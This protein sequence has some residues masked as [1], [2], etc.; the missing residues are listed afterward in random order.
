MAN[1]LK[2]IN[3][4]AESYDIP[5]EDVLFI[6]LNRKGVITDLN[7]ERLRFYFKIT[8]NT[9]FQQSEKLNIKNFFFAI[10]THSGI[11]NYFLRGNSIFLNNEKI[12]EVW[13]IENDTCES[14]YPRREGTVFNLNTQ[15][16]SNCRGCVFCHTFTQT[17]KDVFQ[18]NTDELIKF[19]IKNWLKKY[20][21]SN[22][23]H[24]YRVDVVTGCFGSEEN[25]LNHLFK[26]RKLFSE[27]KFNGEI[28]YFG[29]E[30]TS[31][32]A[33]NALIILKPF[34]LCLS[35]ECFKRRREFLRHHKASISLKRAKEIL[36][37]A[38]DKDFG[39]HFSY[40]LG[41]EPLDL[42]ITKMKEFSAY[43]N[44]LPVINLFQP[45]TLHQKKLLHPEA[46]NLDYFLDARKDLEKLFVPFKFIPRTWGNYR[47]LWY[48][49]F[50]ETCLRDSRIP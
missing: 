15:P 17:A 21:K 9:Y 35:L 42:V 5:F 11:S 34:S 2:E 43:I 41:L 23:S 24:L 50:G 32:G 38:K 16:K 39:T 36:D 33:L 28:F 1:I 31:E 13:G 12:G 3:E 10:P 30:I 22:L 46:L 29:S 37:L 49:K 20:N 44:R 6:D 27:Y 8:E 47:C 14:V 4:L 26:V 7:Y 48:L 45:H 40:I 19:H 18:L 25:V